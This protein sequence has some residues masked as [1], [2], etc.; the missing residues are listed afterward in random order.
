M[1]TTSPQSCTVGSVGVLW[2]HHLRFF[3]LSLTN[4]EK[5]AN[6]QTNLM[7]RRVGLCSL[8]W[9]VNL[10]K[11]SFH[12]RFTVDPAGCLVELQKQPLFSDFKSRLQP[13]PG[14][15]QNHLQ[16]ELTTGMCVGVILGPA[17]SCWALPRNQSAIP[18]S[19]LTSEL[20]SHCP[21]RCSSGSD[22]CLGEIG[23]H[24]TSRWGRKTHGPLEIL[25]LDALKFASPQLKIWNSNPPRTLSWQNYIAP[26]NQVPMYPGTQVPRYT[27]TPPKHLSAQEPWEHLLRQTKDTTKILPADQMMTDLWVGSATA[28]ATATGLW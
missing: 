27:G 26:D 13:S 21:A 20:S 8:V 24:R 6:P 12:L 9:W 23:N 10:N 14:E 2:R 1:V 11:T 15:I 16:S 28:T 19:I 5:E 17:S 3:W 4:T 22:R 25:I 18:D 7:M